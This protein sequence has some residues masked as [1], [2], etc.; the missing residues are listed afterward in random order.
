MMVIDELIRTEKDPDM[1]CTK[2]F[3][4]HL[5]GEVWEDRVNLINTVVPHQS[6]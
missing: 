3:C 4:L 2:T 5:P 1:A 6:L